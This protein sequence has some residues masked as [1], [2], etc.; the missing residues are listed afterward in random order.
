LIKN[1][2]LKAILPAHIAEVVGPH[3]TAGLHLAR[4][5]MVR[6]NRYLNSS[7]QY[8]ACMTET[9]G[10][11]HLGLSV[12]DLDQTTAFFVEVLG[13][14]EIARDD[15]YPRNAVT[16]GSLRLTLW[17]VDR[18]KQVTGFDRRAN[19]GLHH[20][21]M[22]VDSERR[23]AELAD[24]VAAWPGVE[25]EFMPELLGDGPRRHMMFAEPGGI[26]L[27]LIWPG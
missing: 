2:K 17:Q 14:Q 22:Q 26:R 27:E 9:S 10:L 5:A 19:V 3:Q 21:A 8:E 4:I 15:S 23:L 11:N 1:I 13:W 20:L 7:E 25:V 16:D 12:F 6:K 18:S 24:R